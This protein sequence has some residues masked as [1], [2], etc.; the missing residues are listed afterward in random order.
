[1]KILGIIGIIVASLGIFFSACA[2]G[3]T[4]YDT[5]LVDTIVGYGFL[6]LIL[7]VYF[8]SMSIVALKAR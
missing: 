5:Y 2:M 6:G 7:S 3:T 4:G 1:M 8:L